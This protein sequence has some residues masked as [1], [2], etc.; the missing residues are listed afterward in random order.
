MPPASPPCRV[1]SPTLGRNATGSGARGESLRP[2]RGTGA[3]R[4]QRP[5]STTTGPERLRPQRT[6]QHLDATV[7][8]AARFGSVVGNGLGFAPAL[9]HDATVCDAMVVE[10][11]RHSACAAL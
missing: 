10:V 1:P 3:A 8:R 6:N 9:D 7:L 5:A 11:I 2:I 4:V